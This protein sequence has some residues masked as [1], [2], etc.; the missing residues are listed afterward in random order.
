MVPTVIVT[1][2]RQQDR[3]P[4]ASATAAAASSSSCGGMAGPTGCFVLFW[5]GS[6][7]SS[8]P[9]STSLL[10]SSCARISSGIAGPMAEAPFASRA[11]SPLFCALALPTAPFSCTP[12]VSP[13]SSNGQAFDL[14]CLERLIH[15]MLCTADEGLRQPTTCWIRVLTRFSKGICRLCAS[16]IRRLD[17]RRSRNLLEDMAKQAKH[18]LPLLPPDIDSLQTERLSTCAVLSHSSVLTVSPLAT[19][20]ADAVCRNSANSHTISLAVSP[21]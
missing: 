8:A 3:L 11:V 4:T 20:P 7:A 19:L 17:R 15:S 9:F 16:H 18:R 1:C 12:P 10:L 5:S 2:T 13:G 14:Y 6:P 21:P